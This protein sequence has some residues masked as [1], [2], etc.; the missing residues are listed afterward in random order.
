MKPKHD[1]VSWVKEI[2]NVF[3]ESGIYPKEISNLHIRPELNANDLLLE[4]S[5][6]C[7]INTTLLLEAAIAGIPVVIP[8]FKEFKKTKF[9]GTYFFEDCFGFFDI[10]ESVDDLESMILDRLKNPTIDREIME[11]REAMFERYVS[12]L[13]CDATEKHVSMIKRIVAEGSK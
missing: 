7:G 4:S 11:G 13:N 8:Y 9:D 2:D 1:G 3:K 10:A 6:V 12:S 5:V